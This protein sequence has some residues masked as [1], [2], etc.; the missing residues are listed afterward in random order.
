VLDFHRHG[1]IVYGGELL[2]LAVEV[3]QVQQDQLGLGREVVSDSSEKRDAN[4]RGRGLPCG[5]P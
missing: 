2:V 5:R 1:Q 3:L 4:D